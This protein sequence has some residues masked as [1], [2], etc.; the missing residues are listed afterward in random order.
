MADQLTLF[1]I[2]SKSYLT[3]GFNKKFILTNKSSKK[4]I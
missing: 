1:K 2:D 3:L 4:R